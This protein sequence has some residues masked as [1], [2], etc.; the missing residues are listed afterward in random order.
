MTEDPTAAAHTKPLER[1]APAE[2]DTSR[3]DARAQQPAGYVSGNMATDAH[4]LA[5][6]GWI[7]GVFF[8]ED[9]TEAA[10]AS[11]QI[12]VKYWS[13]ERGGS[14]AHPMKSSSTIEWTLI[15]AGKVRAEIGD[16]HVIL[17]A[18]D[19]ALIH[20]GT[21]NNVVA[22]VLEDVVGVTIKSP[23]NPDAKTVLPDGA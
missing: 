15:I 17:S 21:P 11:E 7:V 16:E 23:S 3:D 22:E 4:R 19:Y 20:P 18:G 12:E 6:R 2:A 5:R 13:F 8:S 1:D 10:R 9:P 14:A